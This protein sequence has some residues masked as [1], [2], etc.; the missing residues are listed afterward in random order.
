M[1]GAVSSDD[2][3]MTITYKDCTKESYH[4]SS[5]GTLL[6]DDV[7]YSDGTGKIRFNIADNTVHWDDDKENAGEDS[8][9]RYITIE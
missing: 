5:D 7:E 8:V 3:E 4:Y 2:Q 1:S 6:S 9:F